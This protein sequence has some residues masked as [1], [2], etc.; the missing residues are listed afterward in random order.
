MISKEAFIDH[1]IFLRDCS[2]KGY[3]IDKLLGVNL[4]TEGCLGKVISRYGTLLLESLPREITDKDYEDFWNAMDE[5][6]DASFFAGF[7]MKK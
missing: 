5:G 1:A 6:Y 7:Y 3:Q 2:V 4:S